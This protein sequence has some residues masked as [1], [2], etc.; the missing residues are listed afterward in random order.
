MQQMSSTGKSAKSV[1][2]VVDNG[3]RSE[4]RFSDTFADCINSLRD[5]NLMRRNSMSTSSSSCEGSDN[6]WTANP[7]NQVIVMR[8]SCAI[9]S[10]N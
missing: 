3:L 10:F 8:V 1:S 4:R 9:D 7:I 6:E 2:A 5:V